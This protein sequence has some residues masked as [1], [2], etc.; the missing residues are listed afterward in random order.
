M[1]I[2]RTIFSMLTLAVVACSTLNGIASAECATV[3][4]VENASIGN[5]VETDEFT[6]YSYCPET[7]EERYIDCD[8]SFVANQINDGATI[9]STPS[10]LG[11]VITEQVGL[12]N[13]VS[14]NIIIGSDSR[15]QITNTTI[16]PY[17]MI[18]LVETCWKDGT[19]TYGTG[20][21]VGSDILLTSAQ[22]GYNSTYGGQAKFINVYP[23]L[24]GG[25]LVY[26]QVCAKSV[27]VTSA[28]KTLPEVS[29]NWS[30]IKLQTLNGGVT[31]VGDTTGYF[32]LDFYVSDSIK[33]RSVSVIG[34]PSD[35]RNGTNFTMWR[36]N[37]TVTR[38]DNYFLDYDCDTVDESGA[39]VLNSSNR[40][41][42]VHARAL[43]NTNYGVKISSTLLSTMHNVIDALG[44]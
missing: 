31:T 1:K 25:N 26:G 4:E 2:R 44:W 28:W 22:N 10:Y 13:E 23:G 39:P 14:P 18:C 17:R 43:N 32:G 35:K 8:T 30:L 36:G 29:E 7:G 11:D 20:C 38:V 15:Y 37:G 33:G 27:Y 3:T 16:S 6:I 19:V 21:L 12:G 24:N 41:V 9:I 5:H 40:I 42:A 34:Y